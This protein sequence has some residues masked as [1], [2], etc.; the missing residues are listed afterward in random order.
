M[1]LAPWY[2]RERLL[3]DAIRVAMDELKSEMIDSIE[4]Q[5]E[6]RILVSAGRKRLVLAY[7]PVSS[8]PE[9]VPVGDNHSWSL[10]KV[11]IYDAPEKSTAPR[12]WWS[13]LLG[14]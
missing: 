14:R 8:G 3:Y 4:V 6:N 7:G 12:A 9:I 2:Y 5:S 1:A 10:R 13:K 11:N